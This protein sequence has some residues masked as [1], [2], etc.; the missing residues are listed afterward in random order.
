VTQNDDL[1]AYREAL[2]VE[3]DQRRAAGINTP[4]EDSED[5]YTFVIDLRG[6]AQFHKL[7]DL[8]AARGHSETRI[9]KILG[10]NLLRLYKDVWGA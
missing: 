6:P 4:G 10:A 1:D 7:A 9:D 8:L 5:I 3:N 2:K